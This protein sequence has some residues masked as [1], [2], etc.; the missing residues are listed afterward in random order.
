MHLENTICFG[1]AGNF[2]HHLAQA[3]ELKDFEDVI[4]VEEHAPKGIFPFYLPQS[5]SFLGVYAIGTE[6][7]KLPNYE[8]NTQVEPEIAIL[9]DIVYNEQKEV[10]NLVAQ[11][12]S[13]FNDCT[14]RKEGSKK[15]SDK[16][17]W[18][19]DSKGISDTWIE[20]DTFEKGGIMDHYRLCS[21]LKRDGVLYPY[22]EDAPLVGYSYF[23]TKLKT[24]LIHQ[25]NHQKDFGPLEDIA[26]H[27]KACK[28]P[29]QTLISIGATA[30]EV[31]GEKN[32]LQHGDEIYIITYDERVDK[33]DFSTTP[34][35]SVVH[36]RVVG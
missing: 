25:M 17:S 2:A 1:V 20:I 19:T 7:L 28:Y 31:F 6:I 12:F 3:G 32:Y 18:G 21:F 30:Y 23:Y 33:A 35:K 26:M 10:I 27:L 22:G 11:K 15:I 36:Q 13:A 16:K 29:T 34:T 14:I 9:F 24:W 5:D 4:T 8:A